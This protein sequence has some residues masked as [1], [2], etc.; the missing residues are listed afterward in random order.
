MRYV[1]WV[2]EDGTARLIGGQGPI[3][4]KTGEAQRSGEYSRALGP[5]EVVDGTPVKDFPVGFTEVQTF[6]PEPK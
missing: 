4:R 1:V 6:P 5:E 2:R 3:N